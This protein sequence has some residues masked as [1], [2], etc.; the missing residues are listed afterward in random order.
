MTG[1]TKRKGLEFAKFL[2]GVSPELREQ[3]NGENRREAEEQ[4]KAF[5]A[6]FKEGQCSFCGDTLSSFDVAKPCRHWLLKPTGFEKKHFDIL[7]QKFSWGILENYLRWVANEGAFARNINDLVDEGTGKVVE[8]TI[9]YKNLLWS[10]SCGEGDLSGHDSESSLSKQPHYHFQ[11]YVD[12]KPFIR[13][14]DFHCPLSASDV[15]FLEYKRANPGKVHSR[16]AGGAGMRE[17]LHESTLEKIVD[18]SRPG[19]SADDVS[20]APIALDSMVF[21]APGKKMKGE[22]IYNL[23]QQAKAEGVTFAKKLKD[24]KGTGTSLDG[25]SIQTFISPGPGV[26]YQAVRSGR[27]R[28]GNLQRREQDREWRE[29]QKRE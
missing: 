15:G 20:A 2:A 8:L 29:K 26:V 17:I 28:R 5:R 1:D 7:A 27:K 18:L 6:N 16:L 14:N 21:A 25:A 24:I 23:M 3:V 10:F 9:K 11:M 22:D 4:H 19:T 13:Y 12:D